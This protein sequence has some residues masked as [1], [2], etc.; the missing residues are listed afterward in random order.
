MANNFYVYWSSSNTWTS[1]LKTSNL[2]RKLQNFYHWRSSLKI[3]KIFKINY[4]WFTL[5]LKKENIYE[6]KTHNIRFPQFFCTCL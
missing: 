4:I 6:W 1:S 3:I 2:K 5:Q